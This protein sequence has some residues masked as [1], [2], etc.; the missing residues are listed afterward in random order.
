M[1]SKSASTI[2]S[3][4]G[5]V[6]SSP[7]SAC[8]NEDQREKMD[9]SACWKNLKGVSNRKARSPTDD[10]QILSFYLPQHQYC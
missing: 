5:I 3:V 10:K 9:F 4:Q 7:L 8:L 6:N 1:G 2:K